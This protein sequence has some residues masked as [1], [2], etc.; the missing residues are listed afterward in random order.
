MFILVDKLNLLIG[1]SYKDGAVTDPYTPAVQFGCD[2]RALAGCTIAPPSGS[3]GVVENATGTTCEQDIDYYPYGGV[4]HDY[5]SGTGVAQNYKFN[6]KERDSESGLDNFG[7]RQD[8]SALGRFMIPDWA[9][10]PATVPYAK[11]GDPQSLNLYSFVENGP[12][13]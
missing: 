3:D 4:E 5:C 7:A 13:N 8:A 6:G 10:K 2:G 12:V 11:F 1:K 9:T